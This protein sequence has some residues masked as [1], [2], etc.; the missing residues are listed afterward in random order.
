MRKT[1]M[2]LYKEVCEEVLGESIERHMTKTV[3]TRSSVT[4]AFIALYTLR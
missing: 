2:A 3:H 1:A 4:W